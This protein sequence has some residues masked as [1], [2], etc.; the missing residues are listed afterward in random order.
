LL[1][2]FGGL[3]FRNR[4]RKA[5][6]HRRRSARIWHTGSGSCGQCIAADLR[7]CIA[8][9]EFADADHGASVVCGCGPRCAPLPTW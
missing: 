3:R 6:A 7:P 4:K 9:G 1:I 8:V 5:R 2:Q